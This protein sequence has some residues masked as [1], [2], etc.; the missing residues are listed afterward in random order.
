HKPTPGIG[1]ALADAVA[2]T[3]PAASLGIIETPVADVSPAELATPKDGDGDEDESPEF[4]AASGGLG[5]NP[6]AESRLAA[7][8]DAQL[9][10]MA[11]KMPDGIPSP[12]DRE[13]TLVERV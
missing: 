6:E 7:A 5:I 13:D 4:V 3:N 1:A 11:H 10:E 9:E 12:V 2:A 8:I